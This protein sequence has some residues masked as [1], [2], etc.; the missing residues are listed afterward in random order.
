M[1]E[2]I[3]G[4][5]SIVFPGRFSID[6]TVSRTRR[7]TRLRDRYRN[8]YIILTSSHL[9]H[10]HLTPCPAQ[11]KSNRQQPKLAFLPYINN[12][13]F[14]MFKIGLNGFPKTFDGNYNRCEALF[15]QIQSI[16]SY[17]C[18]NGSFSSGNT[19]VLADNL[20]AAILRTRGHL[21]H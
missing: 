2:Y 5:K 14:P 6:W 11:V 12:G 1:D 19:T 8:N 9:H 16:K 20:V 7:G 3:F 13:V 15:E 4:I 18:P 10:G 17:E 21:P